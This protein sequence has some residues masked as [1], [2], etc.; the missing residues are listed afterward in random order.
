[1]RANS[2]RNNNKQNRIQTI[3]HP[4]H[5]SLFLPSV[6]KCIRL[7]LVQSLLSMKT[8]QETVQEQNIYHAST[9]TYV[10]LLSIHTGGS[11]ST[12]PIYLLSASASGRMEA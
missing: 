11:D 8:S 12:G 2:A 7:P 1:M 10:L 9:I 6:G 3:H 5:S 4:W